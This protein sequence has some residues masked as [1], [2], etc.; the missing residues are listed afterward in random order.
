MLRHATLL[1]VGKGTAFRKLGDRCRRSL[2]ATSS[3]PSFRPVP[4]PARPSPTARPGTDLAGSPGP[5]GKAG[6]Q[7]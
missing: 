2:A 5:G 6:A 3:E 7:D 1:R 4:A